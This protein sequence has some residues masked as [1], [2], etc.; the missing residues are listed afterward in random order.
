MPSTT[1]DRV[2]DAALELIQEHGFG[3]TTVTDIEELAGLSPGSGSFY[4]HFRSKEEVFRAV[5]ERELDR[6][7]R[8]RE[9]FERGPVDD[10]PRAA[11]ARRL[12]QQLDYLARVRPL[13]N[14]LAREHGRFPEVT[15]RIRSVLVDRGIAEEAE[16]LTRDM[17]DGDGHA[18]PHALLAVVVSALTG[19]ELSRG[20]F[21]RP[22]ADVAP[23]RFAAALA[24]LITDPPGGDA[25]S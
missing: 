1:R 2:L 3:G 24:A 11:L 22:P 25:P 7:R 17:P 5:L 6:A 9:E 8:H 19:Y 15:R 4:R 23:E 21:G 10:D 18:D 14:L 12:V 13:I 16:H 20:F